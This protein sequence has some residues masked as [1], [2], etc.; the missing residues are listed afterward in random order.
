MF[1]VLWERV[2]YQEMERARKGFRGRNLEVG[3]NKEIMEPDRTH[4]LSK[5]A[6]ILRELRGVYWLN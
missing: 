4:G 1:I 2:V 6:L 5:Q 3:R